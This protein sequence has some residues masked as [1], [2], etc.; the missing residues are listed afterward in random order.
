MLGTSLIEEV[1]EESMLGIVIDK[2]LSWRSH[3]RVLETELRGRIGILRGLS[4]QFRRDI[5]CGLIQAIFT[6]KLIYGLPLLNNPGGG[7]PDS[8]HERLHKLHHAAMKAALCLSF[9]EHPTVDELYRRSG[10]KPVAE[11]ALTS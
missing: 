5:L 8:A 2:S 7:E 6:S 4:Y 10:Q 1:G 3:P 9:H 11:I